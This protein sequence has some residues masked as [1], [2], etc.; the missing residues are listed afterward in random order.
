MKCNTIAFISHK[1]HLRPERRADEL[2]AH[3]ARAVF[4]VLVALLRRDLLEHLRDGCAVLGVKVGVDFVEEVKGCWV[5]L[6]DCE[7]E[8]EGT[9][10]WGLLAG[11]GY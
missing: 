10:T 6:L 3:A 8:G 5:A 11:D 7:D 1:Q 9:Q 2:S 4:D